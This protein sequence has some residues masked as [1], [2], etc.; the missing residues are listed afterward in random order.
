[1]LED[2][3]AKVSKFSFYTAVGLLI[4]AYTFNILGCSWLFGDYLN[5]SVEVIL[6]YILI[7]VAF[8]SL[9]AQYGE[10]KITADK[11]VN[12]ERDEFLRKERVVTDM[13]TNIARDLKRE[14]MSGSKQGRFTVGRR[15]AMFERDSVLDNYSTRK[16]DFKPFGDR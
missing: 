15:D 1:M 7:T 6:S 4:D 12:K 2:K 14:R 9:Q 5:D 11:A 16:A 10:D 13:K 8:L 3:Y